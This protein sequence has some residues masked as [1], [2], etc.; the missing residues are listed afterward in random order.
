[1]PLYKD[2]NCIG[3][4]ESF[5]KQCLRPELYAEV[6]ERYSAEPVQKDGRITIDG[7]EVIWSY[8]CLNVQGEQ[9]EDAISA[10]AAEVQSRDTTI[11]WN[12]PELRRLA[13]RD[14]LAEL[15]C[16]TECPIIPMCGY[17]HLQH[18]RDLIRN[19]TCMVRETMNEEVLP[20]AADLTEDLETAYIDPRWSEEKTNGNNENTE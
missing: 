6:A 4:C 8:Y 15:P 10:I 14:W 18:D 9:R 17:C 1:M 3:L 13:E 7:R 16:N 5:N 12:I 20:I 19:G 2:A 11:K